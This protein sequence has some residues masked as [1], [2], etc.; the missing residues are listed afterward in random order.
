MGADIAS[1]AQGTTIF[2]CS[3][4]GAARTWAYAREKTAVK[5]MD[6]RQEG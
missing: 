1:I 3:I 6:K 5:L 4:C 2:Y